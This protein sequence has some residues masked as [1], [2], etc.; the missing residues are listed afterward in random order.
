MPDHELEPGG[1][2]P[3]PR[4]REPV[5]FDVFEKDGRYLG[6]VDAPAA[7]STWPR[8]VFRGDNVWGTERDTL[9]VQYVV[10]YRIVGERD[11]RTRNAP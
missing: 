2:P 4:F 5:V 9:G 10:R 8:P 11:A 7:F 6:R 3:V 1:G